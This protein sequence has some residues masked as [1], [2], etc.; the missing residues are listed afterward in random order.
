MKMEWIM[1]GTVLT[2]Q[3]ETDGGEQMLKALFLGGDISLAQVAAVTGLE[4]YTVQNWVAGGRHIRQPHGSIGTKV[5]GD[6]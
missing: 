3:R 6:L 5:S 4:P 2:A 1:P